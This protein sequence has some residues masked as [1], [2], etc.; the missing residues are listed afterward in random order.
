MDDILERDGDDARVVRNP[1]PAQLLGLAGTT[2]SFL[3][4]LGLTAAGL[5]WPA[6]WV[7][8]LLVGLAGAA[9]AAAI[10]PQSPGNLAWAGAAAALAFFVALRSGWDTSAPFLFGALAVLAFAAA[11]LML[12]PRVVRRVAVS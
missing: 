10:A 2:L 1:R 12:L 3:L 7:V 4:C 8:P 9:A 6:V 5:S 11:G